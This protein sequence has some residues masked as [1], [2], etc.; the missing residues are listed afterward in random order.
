MRDI[1][2]DH[3]IILEAGGVNPKHKSILD[4]NPHLMESLLARTS[5]L[6]GDATV[7]ERL[8][9][10]MNSIN[11]RPVCASC[12]N[13]T[14]FVLSGRK[15]NTYNEYC[16]L[17][18]S[19]ASDNVKQKKAATT[20]AN[21]GVD[22]P[23][24]SAT[25]Q[26]KKRETCMRNHGVEY[27]LLSQSI[28]AKSKI[29]L[30]NNFGVDNPMYSPDVVARNVQHRK[31]SDWYEDVTLS[32]HYVKLS[33]KDWIA[34]QH[35]E[36]NKSAVAIA[37]TLNVSPTT[38]L[39][40]L[41]H[42]NIEIKHHFMSTAHVEIVEFLESE[43][44]KTIVSN[45]RKLIQPHEIDIYLPEYNIG[46]EYNGL[47]WHSEDGSPTSIDRNYHLN[48][49]ELCANRGI[50]LIHI[51]ENEWINNTDVVKS[52]LKHI[53]VGSGRRVY[54]RKTN[55]VMLNPTTIRSHMDDWH[56]QGTKTGSYN[57][58]LESDGE[59]V[60]IMTL[61]KPRYSTVYQYELLR[62]CTKPDISVVGGASKLFKQF[63]RDVNPENVV[64]YADRR[65]SNGNV[66]ERLGF[67]HL[68]NSKPNYFY[69]ELKYKDIKLHSRVSFQK[70]KLAD[71]LEHFD[72]DLSESQ[73]MFN[74][75]YRRIWDCGNQVWV[76]NNKQ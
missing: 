26:D 76:W 14:K 56:I 35:H 15:R 66:Y 58:G 5:F 9:V 61:G 55:L 43:G 31:Q 22:N 50:R 64:S 23:S 16:S 46:I 54:A 8:Y 60:A 18:C 28:V 59:L 32:D 30:E 3:N 47:F 12:S 70:H 75:G 29:T 63:I 49:T 41:H 13:P 33:D 37:S 11:T 24:Q 68:H 21:Y 52:R 25:I 73:N 65:W 7:R 67:T 38:V 53:I 40:W 4:K 74:N 72:S 57:I 48:K 10:V 44:V 19:N 39:N 51:F 17:S 1:L 69:V 6:D 36:E 20:Q 27:P 34:N 45:S 2:T 62:Y 42:H 71:K